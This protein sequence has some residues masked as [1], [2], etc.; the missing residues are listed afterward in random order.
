MGVFFIKLLWW[1]L[2][3]KIDFY[4]HPRNC[5][6]GD[7]LGIYPLFNNCRYNL[8]Q[9]QVQ[10]PLKWGAAPLTL[11][12]LSAHLFCGRTGKIKTRQIEYARLGFGRLKRLCLRKTV[13]RIYN[14]SSIFP[15]VKP[16]KLQPEWEWEILLTRTTSLSYVTRRHACWLLKNYRKQKI[17]FS[18]HGALRLTNT[19]PSRC[20]QAGTML[21]ILW[22]I[23]SVVGY[24]VRYSM[25][26][27]LCG[28]VSVLIKL[29]PLS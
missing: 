25:V 7:F 2:S 23:T 29:F 5:S 14:I 3:R 11:G 18:T 16:L 1:G 4:R 10:L 12:K 20:V 27:P 17:I 22:C 19:R 28:K 21:D 26:H 8:E 6:E 13:S 15:S 24:D 9:L